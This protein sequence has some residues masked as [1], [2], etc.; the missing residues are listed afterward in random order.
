MS[1]HIDPELAM[2][3]ELREIRKKLTRLTLV[4]EAAV[5]LAVLGACATLLL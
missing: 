3:D 1:T 4:V 2:L 5:I